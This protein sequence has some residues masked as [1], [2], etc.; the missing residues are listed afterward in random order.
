MAGGRS[1]SESKRTNAGSNHNKVLG[2]AR[3]R[4]A[5]NLA[6]TIAIPFGTEARTPQQQTSLSQ[7]GYSGRGGGGE[8]E[9]EIL[10]YLSTPTSRFS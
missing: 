1:T 2:Q 9:D 3:A 4:A 8:K 7:N 6:R 5:E 10:I